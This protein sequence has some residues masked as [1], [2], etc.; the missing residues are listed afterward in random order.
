MPA[1]GDHRVDDPAEQQRCQHR[2][3]LAATV[4]SRA[5]TSQQRPWRACC[6][7]ARPPPAGR[8]RQQGPGRSSQHRLGVV[9]TGSVRWRADPH[10]PD[11][12]SGRKITASQRASSG[13]LV[14]MINVARSGPRRM[15]EPLGD[16]A[17]GH[18]VHRRGRIPQHQHRS[19]GQQSA[20]Q[21]DA[22]PLPTGQVQS[23]ISQLV[24]K[25]GR[26]PARS[27]RAAAC[28]RAGPVRRRT[29]IA[30]LQGLAERFAEEVDDV[31]LDQHPPVRPPGPG[32][33][34]AARRGRPSRSRA[35]PARR[36]ARPASRRR[37]W[38]PRRPRRARPVRPGASARRRPAALTPSAPARRPGLGR[39]IE[40]WRS[41]GPQQF[42]DPCGAGPGARVLPERAADVAHRVADEGGQPDHGDQLTDADPAL[43]RE[44]SRPPRPPPPAGPRR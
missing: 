20:G 43:D 15:P 24:I 27:S 40:R 42:A 38:T 22:L 17:L 5:M 2:P 32:R 36:A 30:D 10:R 1:L 14:V 25:I 41:D 44:G 31:R 6:Q 16:Q 18:R 34:A 3:T 29:G 8:D 9:G 39:P 7:S 4:V 21:G 26:A 12:S 19:I 28:K 23:M 13:G 37:P 33:P 35:R 11:R